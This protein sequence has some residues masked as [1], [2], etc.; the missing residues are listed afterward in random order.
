MMAASLA[1][2]M[3]S[4]VNSLED[5]FGLLENGNPEV[6]LEI[7]QILR[8]QFMD[9][10]NDIS[11]FVSASSFPIRQHL[12]ISV[13][14]SWLVHGLYDY[15]SQ[16]PKDSPRTLELLLNVQDPHDRF[17]CDKLAEGLRQKDSKTAKVNALN[18]FGY[19]IRGQPG[20]LYRVTQHALMKELIKVLKVWPRPLSRLGNEIN[21][22]RFPFF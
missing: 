13:R 1:A 11:E 18:I 3:T 7:R 12:S 20:W 6:V 19:L 16:H 9:G 8:D 21:P 10:R 2:R 15:I 17:L 4:Q 22:F 5:L 14:E